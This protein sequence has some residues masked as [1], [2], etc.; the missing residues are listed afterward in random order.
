MT[1]AST[2][3]HP[4]FRTFWYFFTHQPE[5]S[6][7][8]LRILIMRQMLESPEH[9]EEVRAL[10]KDIASTDDG[11]GGWM[12]A[13]TDIPPESNRLLLRWLWVCMP[14]ASFTAWRMARLKPWEKDS[15]K[16]A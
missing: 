11:F 8:A 10:A 15:D 1:I 6:A 2:K 14:R 13:A 5:W 4:T 9:Q 16:E 12:L 7:P 3:P